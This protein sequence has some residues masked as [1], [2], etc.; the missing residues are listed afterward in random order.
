MPTPVVPLRA[1]DVTVL[2]EDVSSLIE[3]I[4]AHLAIPWT[5]GATHTGRPL[6]LYIDNSRR[7]EV[8]RQY[9]EAGWRI[10][11]EMAD[12]PNAYVFYPA[13]EAKISV[14]GTKTGRVSVAKAPVDAPRSTEDQPETNHTVV[15]Q[16]WE[17]S[18]RGWGVRPDGF[19]L[20][21]TVEDHAAFVEKFAKQFH[22]AKE[23]PDEYTRTSGPTR[24]VTVD[25]ATYNQLCTSK[26]RKANGMWV[27]SPKI[28]PKK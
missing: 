4:N 12:N 9:R 23:A 16:D 15:C 6:T 7:A 24:L 19:T 21:L 27:H 3:Q 5:V 26:N 11:E 8:F 20:H 17:E 14:V 22:S 13:V 25:E 10:V 18:E 28:G 1:T 2:E